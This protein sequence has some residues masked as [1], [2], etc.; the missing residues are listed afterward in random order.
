VPKILKREIQKGIE[1]KLFKG[2][3]IVIYG[4]R[5]TGKTTLVSLIQKKFE[6]S[7]YLNCDEIDIRQKLGEKTS[8]E[9]LSL[10]GN[11]KI[12]IIDEAQRVKNIGLTIKL[13]VDNAKD[14]QVIATGSSAFE[15]SDK[16]KE[17]LTGRAFEFYLYPFSLT[18]LKEVYNQQQLQRIIEDRMIFGMYPEVVL[19]N[20]KDIL[21]LL[22]DNYLYKDIL[23]YKNIKNHDVLIRLLQ[24]IALQIGK[25][26]SYN[27]LAS[28]VGIDKKTIESYIMILEQAFIIF[29][30]GPFSRNLRNELK[31]LRKI[32]FYDTGIRNALINNFNQL[33]IRQDS[34]ALFENFIISERLKYN[35]NNNLRKNLYFWRTHQQQEIDYLEEYE[36]QLKGYEIKLSKDS[37]KAPK[38]FLE[39]Y[40]N[41]SVKLIN[42]DNCLDWL[43]E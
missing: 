37:F 28:L 10:I 34:G 13:I 5:Q 29:R 38:Q 18:E 40:K 15:L 2:K 20:D 42:K 6:N 3:A 25:E 17:S 27:E 23:T 35:H 11:K 21:S 19:K 30:L 36:G 24:A 7:L 26:V 41:S 16:I 4:A 31:K 22:A 9:L 43:L 1:N 14:V 8:T 39:T 33:H 12:V 32:Y